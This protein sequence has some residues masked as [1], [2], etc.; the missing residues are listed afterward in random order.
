M[1]LKDNHNTDHSGDS[2]KTPEEVMDE[3]MSY[4]WDRFIDPKMDELDEDESTF[5]MIAGL[6]LKTIAITATLYEE[7]AEAKF[8]TGFENPSNWEKN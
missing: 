6:A 4:I 7:S 5:V 2:Q 8:P 1:Y 3:I